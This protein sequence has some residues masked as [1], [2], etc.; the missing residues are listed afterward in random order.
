MW[1]EI[2][3]DSPSGFTRIFILHGNVR[4]AVT[5]VAEELGTVSKK[6]A[7][8][9]YLGNK[10]YM[11]DYLSAYT[12]HLLTISNGKKALRRCTL[13]GVSKLQ[14]RLEQN[15][16]HNLPNIYIIIFLIH[17]RVFYWEIHHS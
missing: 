9:D 12:L 5:L 2:H 10:T 11:G 1:I 14:S 15:T 7:R 8:G 4:A 16:E 3:F 17:A 13:L 6:T